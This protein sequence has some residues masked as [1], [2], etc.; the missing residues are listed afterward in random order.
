MKTIRCFYLILFSALAVP[1]ASDAQIADNDA[2]VSVLAVQC[3]VSSG[4]SASEYEDYCRRLA[5]T[6][7]LLSSDQ[8]TRVFGYLPMPGAAS[9]GRSAPKEGA[10]GSGNTGQAPP[11][12]GSTQG[13]SERNPVESGTNE[14]GNSAAPTESNRVL[15]LVGKFN[16]LFDGTASGSAATP[17]VSAG[18]DASVG[19]SVSSSGGSNRPANLGALVS[20]AATSSNGSA[21]DAVGAVIDANGGGSTK[22]GNSGGSNGW[23]SLVAWFE[24]AEAAYKAG[25]LSSFLKGR[26]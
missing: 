4:F 2:S 18:V 21:S 5:K 26:K 19:A 9:L 23:N 8:Q 12:T 11:E 7:S 10:A 20:A 14:L 15:D 16:S 17:V 24:A 1:A 13:G 22:T 25:N 3:A 6:L